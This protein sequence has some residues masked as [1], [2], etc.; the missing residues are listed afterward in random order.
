MNQHAQQIS[1]TTFQ[2]AQQTQNPANSANANE[3]DLPGPRSRDDDEDSSPIVQDLDLEDNTSCSNRE[4]AT[5]GQTNNSLTH[6]GSLFGDPTG[7]VTPASP[8]TERKDP[9][10]SA[11]LT[12][13]S[14]K[15]VAQNAKLTAL[16][17]TFL[18]TE[19]C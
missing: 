3:C 4:M 12:A 7:G 13:I 10:G 15:S 6:S 19:L 5:F 8:I 9:H 11:K 18:M 17:T 2:R 14:Q 16:P 1:A